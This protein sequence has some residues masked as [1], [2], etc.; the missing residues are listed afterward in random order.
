MIFTGYCQ[1]EAARISLFNRK[2]EKAW[3]SALIFKFSLAAYVN[4]PVLSSKFQTV[5]AT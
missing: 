1:K 3:L 4:S 2:F 5:F